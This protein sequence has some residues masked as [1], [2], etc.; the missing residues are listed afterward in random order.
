MDTVEWFPRHVT[1]PTHSATDLVIKAAADLT[2]ALANPCPNSPLDPLADSEIHKLHELQSILRNRAPVT[3]PAPTP[4]PLKVSFAPTLASDIP[5]L[6]DRQLRRRRQRVAPKPTPLPKPTPDTVA[7]RIRSNPR[8]KPNQIHKANAAR[9]QA[10]TTR[11]ALA[12]TQN[13]SANLPTSTL[14]GAA[15]RKPRTRRKLQA[16]I[17]L[18][19]LLAHRLERM[20]PTHSHPSLFDTPQVCNAINIDTGR[21]AGYQELR[22]KL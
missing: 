3:P 2:A 10:A 20:L 7:T 13:S 22:K 11:K 16:A 12:R 19:Q 1:M 15:P 5:P 4:Q 17:A 8:R 14:P 18:K 9:A 6:T 21:E